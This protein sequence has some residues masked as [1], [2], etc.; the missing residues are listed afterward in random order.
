MGPYVTGLL[1]RSVVMLALAQLL[2]GAAVQA[3]VGPI[4]VR[5]TTKI[6]LEIDANTLNYK[7]IQP[8]GARNCRLCSAQLAAK[9]GKD[10][11]GAAKDNINI[12]A[13]L[14][15][16]TV[17]DLNQIM[18]LRSHKNPTCFSLGSSMTGGSDV[19]TQFCL[20]NTNETCPAPMWIE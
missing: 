13:G 7:V 17:Q 9:Y 12:C 11:A 15:Q 4:S 6:L 10:C 8:E 19:V 1:G 3:E 14:V 16:A 18:L 2:C 20:C 5:P